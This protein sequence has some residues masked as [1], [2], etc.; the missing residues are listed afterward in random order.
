[1]KDKLGEVFEGII[2]GVSEWGFYV[3]LSDNHCEGMVPMRELDD[4]FYEYDETNYCLVGMRN[5]R[6]FSIGQKVDV[7]ILSANL[8][9][10]QLDF[11]LA[12]KI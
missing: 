1:M 2:S 4:D 3:E 11:G 5:R 9:K 7:E 8:A 12:K 10:R 6:M